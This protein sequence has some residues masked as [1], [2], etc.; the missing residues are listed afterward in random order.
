[1]YDAQPIRSDVVGARTA[2]IVDIVV[3]SNKTVFVMET[4]YP[5]NK[6]D[7]STFAPVNDSALPGVLNF[8]YANQAAYAT[9][10]VDAVVAA[11]GSGLFYFEMVRS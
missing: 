4:G 2:S 7:A 1:M 11:G 9:G 6:D 10:V 5:V 8:T 3:S